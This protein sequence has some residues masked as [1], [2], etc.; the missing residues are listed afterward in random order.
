MVTHVLE[1]HKSTMASWPTG[2]KK[3]VVPFAMHSPSIL[4][5]KNKEM[6]KDKPHCKI[7][8][9]HNFNGPNLLFSLHL[10]DSQL[11]INTYIFNYQDYVVG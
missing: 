6:R 8:L 4:N 1:Y 2:I 7:D 9:T 11:I 10:N 5:H 3:L